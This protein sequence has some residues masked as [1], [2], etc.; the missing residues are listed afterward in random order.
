MTDL[1]TALREKRAPNPLL[2]PAHKK[3]IALVAEGMTPQEISAALGISEKTT[4]SHLCT[5]R[6]R[7]GIRNQERLIVAAVKARMRP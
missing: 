4:S 6:R 7:L 3:I 2:T 5:I 1:A